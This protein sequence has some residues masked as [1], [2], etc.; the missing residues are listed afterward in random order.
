MWEKRLFVLSSRAGLKALLS[1]RPGWGVS[2]VSVLAQLL[3]GPFLLT[4]FPCG[5]LFPASDNF[6][7]FSFF[8]G[9]GS[10]FL[11]VVSLSVS[12]FW[13]CF[14][15]FFPILS[16]FPILPHFSLSLLF[17]PLPLSSPLSLRVSLDLKPQV[18]LLCPHPQFGGRKKS[19]PMTHVPDVHNNPVVW[20]V[21]A[22]STDEDR[23][24]CPGPTVEV[25]LGFEPRP[26]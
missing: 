6:P 24:T 15:F 1:W 13:Y 10:I 16:H 20:V 17:P 7:S 23:A 11:S 3:G 8:L 4:H 19:H 18:S 26:A 21:F 14:F 22:P 5:S 25:G 9:F 12:I 2:F